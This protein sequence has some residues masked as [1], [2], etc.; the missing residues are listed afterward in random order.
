MDLIPSIADFR[1]PPV[2]EVVCG[3]QF[4]PLADFRS[5][6][7]G[8]FWRQVRETYPV[9]RDAA[10]LPPVMEN[11][12][13][14][15]P[16]FSFFSVGGLVPLP[17]VQLVDARGGQMIQIQNGR[18]HHNWEKQQ[19]ED[20]Y[21]RYKNIRPAFVER[22]EQFKRFLG[23]QALGA[24]RPTQYELSYINHV[25]AGE[26][27]DETR[28]VGELLPWFAPPHEVA[29]HVFEPQ[30]AMHSPL[31]KCRGRLHVTG[32]VG[33]RAKDGR[34]VLVFELTVR[35]AP[36]TAGDDDDLVAW[37]DDA[38][39]CIVRSFVALTSERARIHWGQIQ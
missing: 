20:Q 12:G 17:R 7:V 35:G 6:H 19:G 9:A 27:W 24:P 39:E 10:P 29:G 5:A 22:W 25:V 30:F 2:V 23:D 13:A 28:G 4:E 26:L 37:M 31:P 16:A 8:L 33:V 38:R 32:K 34:H 11:F 21:R 15:S 3:V 36:L 1:S 14:P 18:F